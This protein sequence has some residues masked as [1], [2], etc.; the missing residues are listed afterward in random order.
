MFTY[1][2]LAQEER[3]K[4]TELTKDARKKL[5]EAAVAWYTLFGELPVGDD[6]IAAHEIYERIRGSTR[7]PF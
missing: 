2:E 7:G 5:R 6:R 3:E 4:L 1:T